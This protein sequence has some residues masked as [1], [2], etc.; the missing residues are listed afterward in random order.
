MK[1]IFEGVC[2]A[3]ITPFMRDGN[4]DFL[5]FE[6][7]IERQIATGVNALCILG[8]TGEACTM[9]FDEKVSVVKFAV[10][11]IGNR[12]PIIFGI[13]GNNP[14][15]VIRFGL[16]VR[17]ISKRVAVMLTAPY[18]NKC[19]QDAAVKWFDEISNAIALP[20][21]V[22][23]IPTR[24]GMNLEPTTLQKICQLKYIAG[25]KDSCGNMSK[26]IDTVRLC[27]NTAVYCGDDGIALP[28]YAVGCKG[29]ISVASNI[30]PRETIE[31]WR[32]RSTEMF[33]SEIPRY[34]AL[35]CEVNP[36][37]IKYAMHINGL[38]EATLRSPLTELN[39][40]NKKTIEKWFANV[41]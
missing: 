30:C 10:E 5:A 17:A 6:K 40:E 27:K 1:K 25:I 2:T 16:A 8:T 18:Y 15:E 38:C 9:N 33:N 26:I 4:I 32:T 24:A 12:V 31:I 23:N 28:C 3:M 13:G 29:L 37:P 19:T 20:M 36:A 14:K 11:K 7:H 21:I 39:D 41:I 34:N 35:F 22:Y